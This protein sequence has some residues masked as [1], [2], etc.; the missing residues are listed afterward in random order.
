MSITLAQAVA[1]LLTGDRLSWGEGSGQKPGAI[2]LD[3]PGARRLPQNAGNLRSLIELSYE[4][5]SILRRA[6]P[7][8]RNLRVFTHPR[9]T[10]DIG[11]AQPLTIGRG[12][13]AGAGAVRRLWRWMKL[14]LLQEFSTYFPS[15]AQAVISQTRLSLRR[16]GTAK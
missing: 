13:N 11:V 3:T 12:R 8:R 5:R 2:R 6:A 10:T 9:P 14:L 7:F 4:N 15:F 1:V 16:F